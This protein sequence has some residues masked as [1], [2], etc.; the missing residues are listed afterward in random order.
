MNITYN[1]Y[2][3]SVMKY[4]S[5]VIDTTNIANMNHLGTAPNNAL[6][7]ICG[8]VKSTPVTFLQ[9]Y[10]ENLPV[11]LEIQKQAAASF[12]NCVFV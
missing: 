8:A 4:D 11:S 3:K 2:V 9:I 6:R 1:T 12:I 7:L 5:E 10:T